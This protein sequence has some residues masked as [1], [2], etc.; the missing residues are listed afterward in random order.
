ME[1]L[2]NSLMLFMISVLL[3]PVFLRQHKRDLEQYSLAPPL[4]SKRAYLMECMCDNNYNK[5][6]G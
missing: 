6:K 4:T 2:Y 3:K 1:D 5:I